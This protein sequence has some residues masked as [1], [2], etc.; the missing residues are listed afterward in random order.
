[1]IEQAHGVAG[2]VHTEVVGASLAQELTNRPVAEPDLEDP[3]AGEGAREVAPEVGV[4]VQVG[5][6]EASQGLA[7]GLLVA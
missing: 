4:V 7:A 6:V 1:M 2:Q 5:R 3:L